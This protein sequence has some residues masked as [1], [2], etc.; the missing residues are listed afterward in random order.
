LSL[1]KER[2]GEGGNLRGFDS[3]YELYEKGVD[4]KKFYISWR[5]PAAR[6]ILASRQD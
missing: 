1:S 5:V 6:R 4:V 2:Q 3:G